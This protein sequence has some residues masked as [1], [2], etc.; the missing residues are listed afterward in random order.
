MIRIQVYTRVT[1]RVHTYLSPHKTRFA[2]LRI[3]KILT[4]VGIAA[5]PVLFFS[6]SEETVQAKAQAGGLALRFYGHGVSAPDL[7]RVKIRVDDPANNLEGPAVDVGAQD[8]TI[9]FW[10][11]GFANEN[12]AAAIDCG[13]N[14]NWINGNIVVDRD[15][16]NQDRKFGISLGAGR[17][18]FG[19]SGDGS[20]DRTICG[21]TSVLDGEWHHVAV[22]RRIS[23]GRMQLFVD[24]SLETT[25]DGPDGDV[26]YPDNGEPGDFCGGRPC[27]GS[28]PFVVLGA[29][30]HDA[31][32]AYPS[33]SGLLDELR[34]SSTLRYGGNFTVPGGPFVPDSNT[35][36]LYHFDEGPVGACTSAVLDSSSGGAHGDCRYGGS[37][38]AGPVYVADNPFASGLPISTS[39]VAPT[40]KATSTPTRTTRPIRSPTPS[41]TP[42]RVPTAYVTPVPSTPATATATA[43]AAPTATATQDGWFSLFVPAVAS[44][45][46]IP[47]GDSFGAL[48]TAVG[49]GLWLEGVIPVQQ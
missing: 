4:V 26:S 12:S 24:G 33:F 13:G 45:R 8:F 25:A 10:I 29:E 15:R 39:T 34:F 3:L 47:A 9:E 28:D 20:G 11:K 17:P 36:G 35:A 6:S 30:K 31:G 49:S 41:P 44:A 40:L 23:D 21:S 14:V 5:L 37:S 27:T 16:Y 46:T 42:T 1:M 43:T 2:R 18:V 48:A 38:P 19:I 22:Q 32:A 7:D